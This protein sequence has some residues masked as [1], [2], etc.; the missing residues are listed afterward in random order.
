MGILRNGEKIK[1]DRTTK[2]KYEGS[3]GYY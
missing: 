1:N 3:S 2:I